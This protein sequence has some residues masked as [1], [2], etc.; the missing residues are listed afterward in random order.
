VQR[1]L[2]PYLEGTGPRYTE[3]VAR[4][5]ARIP[6]PFIREMVVQKVV[7]EARA[8]G[9]DLLSVE[10]WVNHILESQRLFTA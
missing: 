8:E 2:F 7:Q 6:T 1:V 3:G 4:G 10:H 9:E 5:V